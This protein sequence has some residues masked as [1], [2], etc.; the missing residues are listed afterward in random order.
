METLA[1]RGRLGEVHRK[2]DKLTVKDLLV[3]YLNEVSAQKKGHDRE[4]H[5]INSLLREDFVDLGSGPI[6]F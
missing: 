6:N 4:T 2:T 1:D 5:F 3:R